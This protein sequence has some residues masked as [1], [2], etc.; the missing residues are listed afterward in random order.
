MQ[1]EIAR[2][3]KNKTLKRTEVELEAQDLKLVPS[4]KELKPKIAAMLNAKEELLVITKIGH[5]FGSRDITVSANVY[6]NAEALKNSEA[7]YMMERGGKKKGEEAAPKQEKPD[8]REAAEESKG[9]KKA[10]ESGKKEAE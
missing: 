9:G 10:E 7:K 1:L 3:K 8:A 4:R 2:Q 5:S 6:E